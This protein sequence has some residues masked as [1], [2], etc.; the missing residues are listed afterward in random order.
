MLLLLFLGTGIWPVAAQKPTDKTDTAKI[1]GTIETFSKKNKFTGFLYR[2]IFK[3][4]TPPPFKRKTGHQLAPFIKPQVTW[5]TNRFPYDSL[6]IN[7]ENGIR[8]FTASLRG[9]KKIILTLQT[10]SY[11]PWNVLG[12]RFGPYLNCSIGSLGNATSGFKKSFVYSQI[13]IGALIKNNFLVISDFQFS[14]AYYP[15]IP[16]NGFN[17]LKV[18]SYSTADFGFRD[19][20]FGKPEIVAF[21]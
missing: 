8:G 4:R 20:I 10:Q 17:T 12:F 2:L 19:F 3:P 16:G 18:N 11:A 21:Q 6:T 5:G 13:G 15:S 7:N 14:I 9:T 1:Y